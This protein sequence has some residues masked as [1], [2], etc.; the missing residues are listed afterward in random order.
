MALTFDTIN[1][2]GKT[3]EVLT[4]AGTGDTREFILKSVLTERELAVFD[5]INTNG[6]GATLKEKMQ[7]WTLSNGRT[8]FDVYKST[9]RV[10]SS[11]NTGMVKLVGEQTKSSE[12]A[13]LLVKISEIQAIIASEETDED[14]VIAIGQ[15]LA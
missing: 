10:Y 15:V 11:Y 2:A 1:I 9:I 7:A 4:L 3:T 5:D 13:A 12:V 8:A 14:K 6:V